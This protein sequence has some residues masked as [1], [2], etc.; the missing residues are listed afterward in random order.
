MRS[1][2]WRWIFALAIAFGALIAVTSAHDIPADVVVHVYVKPEGQA[3]HVLVRVPLAAMRDV[4]FPTRGPGYLELDKADEALRRSAFVWIRDPLQVYEND[5]PL[6]VPTL[7]AFRVSLPSD[8]SFATRAEATAHLASPPLPRATDLIW[9]QALFDV[10][11]TYPIASDRSDFSLRPGFSRLGVRVVTVLRFAPP[12]T[13]ERAFEYSGD[14]G[15]LRLDPRWHQAAARFVALG[16]EHIL[17]GVDHLLFLLCLVL[18]FRR[19]KALVII[20]TSFTV[21]H[22]ITLI[23]S[24]M[25]LAPDA[26]WFPP[27]IETLIATSV[28]YMALENIYAA[29]A[30]SG[31]PGALSLRRRW[32]MTFA[33]GLVHGFGFSFALRETMQFAGSHLLTSLFAF[34]VG[35]E[36]GQLVVLAVAVPVIAF[37]F[38]HRTAERFGI[39]VVSALVAHTAWHWMIARGA[40]LGEYDWTALQPD[41]PAKIL[42]WVMAAVMVAGAI[43]ILR[44]GRKDASADRGTH[45]DR[46]ERETQTASG[47]TSG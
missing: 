42:R 18:P 20:V 43:W 2:V 37:A 8:R 22:S 23:A 6:D 32:L 11:L 31:S 13:P 36:L 19:F 33:F 15:L 7:V 35:V 12:G 41:S 29:T 4:T 17:D 38:R 25:H 24:A 14:P 26:L 47:G 1:A 44:Q 5:R 30:G 34:N 46:Q 27:L 10:W 9:N 3:L 45:G 16:F 40:S 21:A 28:V 39:V